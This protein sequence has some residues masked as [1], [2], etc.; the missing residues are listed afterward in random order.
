V[1]I[2]NSYLGKVINSFLPKTKQDTFM[3]LAVLTWMLRRLVHVL[4]DFIAYLGNDVIQ[5]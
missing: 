3:H 5:N 1:T 2:S 4:E